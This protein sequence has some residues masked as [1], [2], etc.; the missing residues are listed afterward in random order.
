VLSFIPAASAAFRCDIPPATSRG[1]S[2]PRREGAPGSARAASL[3]A[4]PGEARLGALD[5][6][7]LA[8]HTRLHAFLA[9]AHLCALKSRLRSR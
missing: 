7:S 9:S 4:R 8:A 1:A 5:Q 6:L 3:A 2:R